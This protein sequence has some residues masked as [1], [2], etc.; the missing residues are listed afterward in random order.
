ME[1]YNF[2]A[3]KGVNSCWQRK[4]QLVSCNL[5]REPAPPSGHLENC[6][7]GLI[8]AK[9]AGFSSYLEDARFPC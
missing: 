6:H 8:S 3:S 5:P 7:F 1:L 2:E 9:G 4:V